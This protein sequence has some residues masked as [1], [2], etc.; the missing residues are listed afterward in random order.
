MHFRDCPLA[1]LWEI[2]TAYRTGGKETCWCA[3]I[4]DSSGKVKVR[5]KAG[6]VDREEGL[7]LVNVYG[8]DLAVPAD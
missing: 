5:A 1:V 3:I 2:I 4:L 8:L 7:D 6:S